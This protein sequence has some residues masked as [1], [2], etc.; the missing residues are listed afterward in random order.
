MSTRPQLTYLLT[1]IFLAVTAA[2]LFILG[3]NVLTTGEAHTFSQAIGEALIVSLV[4]AIVV[5]PRLLQHFGEEIASKSFWTSFYA[6]APEQY[7]NAIQNLARETQFTQAI[8]WRLEFDW[9]DD[10]H[11][12]IKLTITI[13]NF[14]ENRDTK[15]YPVAPYAFAFE[16]RFSN[17]VTEFITY[18]IYSESLT[19]SIDVFLDKRI[20]PQHASDGRLIVFDETEPVFTVEP[21]QRFTTETRFVTY[22]DSIGYYPLTV[23]RPTLCATVQLMGTALNDLFIS[24]LHPGSG[25]MQTKNEGVGTE[26]QKQGEQ[27]EIRVGEVYITGQAVLVS[28]KA[29]SGESRF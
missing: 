8:R 6:R 19:R 23:T 2:T 9:I 26:L 21:D 29:L 13:L 14:R 5:E 12:I 17:C 11:D 10:T 20:Q 16:S 1:L 3:A 15:P 4:V 25:T 7:R 24:V 22:V 18:K 27:G 28:W